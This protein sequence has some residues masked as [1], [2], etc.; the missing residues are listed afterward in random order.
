MTAA[1]DEPFHLGVVGESPS[2]EPP[3]APGGGGHWRWVALAA[4][5]AVGAVL[6]LVVS[7]ARHDAAELTEIRVVAGGLDAFTMSTPDEPVSIGVHLLNAGEREIEILGFGADGLTIVPDS[8]DPEPVTAPPGEWV[9]IQQDG[10]VPDCAADPPARLQVRIRDAGGEQRVVE[11]AE[12]P[13]YGPASQLWATC[14]YGPQVTLME[15]EVVTAGP[16]SLL[17]DFPMDNYGADEAELQVVGVES[18]GLR[19]EAAGLPVTVPPGE[20][21]TVGLTWTVSSCAEARQFSDVNLTYTFG[22]SAD[23]RDNP[24]SYVPVSGRA[25]AE[26]VL[27]VDRVCESEE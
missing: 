15:P 14:T 7:D 2:S 23:R 19:V 21:V 4:A 18:P 13:G 5:V 17:T 16:T 9:T 25:R 11:A 27:L 3:P 26:L 24:F 6:G 20:G 22:E 12:L 8:A 10:L 1:H